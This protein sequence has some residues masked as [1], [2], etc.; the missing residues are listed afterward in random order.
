MA[1]I[2]F[3][4]GTDT[5]VGKTVLTAMLL[6]HLRDSGVNALAVKPFSSGSR[7]DAELLM[8]FQEGELTLDEVNPFFVKQP[9]APLVSHK[10]HKSVPLKTVLQKIFSISERCDVLFVEGIGGVMVPLGEKYGVID[11]ISKLNCDVLVASA[12]RL[13]AINHTLLTVNALQAAGI[14]IIKIIMTG[15]KRAD[16]STQ[17][18]AKTVQKLARCGAV[19]SI[20]QLNF[21]RAKIA[22][23]KINVKKMK[24]TLARIL[25]HDN[26]VT[27]LRNTKKKLINKIR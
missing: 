23:L 22:G 18:N 14:K 25:G 3:I 26:F 16:I 8:A 5:G 20:P 12:N 17:T 10:R 1:R 15:G 6:C 13:G 19:I 11:L 21:G 7:E 2:I 9:V 24:K 4:T 27:V